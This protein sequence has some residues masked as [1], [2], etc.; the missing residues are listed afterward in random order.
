MVMVMISV[1]VDKDEKVRRWGRDH[2]ASVKRSCKIFY[3]PESR[4]AQIALARQALGQT[5][6]LCLVDPH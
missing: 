5:F 2:G 4:L 1:R 3:Y 6:K